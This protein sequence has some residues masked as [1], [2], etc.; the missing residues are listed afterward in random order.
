[1]RSWRPGM[2]YYYLWTELYLETRSPWSW[3]RASSILMLLMQCLVA[4]SAMM[5]KSF[6][7]SFLKWHM[8]LRGALSWKKMS[9]AWFSNS[10][11]SQWKDVWGW[12][13]LFWPPLFQPTYTP[14]ERCANNGKRD[15]HPSSQ[16][17]TQQIL[18]EGTVC[19]RHG[20]IGSE[21]MSP[22]LSTLGMPDST[23]STLL[24][25]TQSSQ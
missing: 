14:R 19:M 17:S 12:I 1:M 6:V 15:I 13:G 7:Y 18:A 20:A 21:G 11:Q 9:N 22:P 25:L 5:H 8:L 16:P 24:C 10:S 4:R 3:T 23:L 2:R